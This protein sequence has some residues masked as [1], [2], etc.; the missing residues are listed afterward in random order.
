MQRECDS[1][2]S[3][4]FIGQSPTIS[5]VLVAACMV[6]S[7]GKEE[8]VPTTAERLAHVQ[9]R[10]QTQPDFYVPRKTVDYMADLKSIKDAPARTEVSAAKTAP[11]KVPDAKPAAAEK[12]APISA[13]PV[14]P[15][16]I[17][18]TPALAPSASAP[19]AN[20]VAALAPTSRPQPR[21][22]S[23]SAITVV[24][25][26]QPEFPR[27]ALRAGI[28]NGTVRA[29]MTIGAAGEVTNVAILKAEPARVFDRAVQQAL[30][31]WKF[32]A[33]ADG[34]TFDT[35]VGFKAAN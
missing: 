15:P 6:S 35:E 29:R 9:Q 8:R 12:T 5:M 4:R 24:S 34:R 28:D 22:D 10:Q 17:A 13:A 26:E 25:R 11:A 14:P 3:A 7:C 32:N 30:G 23:A 1:R 19:P 2:D 33:G 16:V 21:A 27:E 20:V 18:S 31:R